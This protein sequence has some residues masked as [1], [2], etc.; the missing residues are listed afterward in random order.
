MEELYKIR[1][2]NFERRKNMTDDEVIAEIEKGAN[3]ALEMIAE[4][5]KERELA[6]S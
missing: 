5:K 6:V 1:E 3:E 4:F 2:E